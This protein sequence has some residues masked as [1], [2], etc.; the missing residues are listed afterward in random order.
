M[1]ATAPG[2]KPELVGGFP[3]PSAP[4]A[5]GVGVGEELA[6]GVGWTV[7]VEVDLV[8]ELL[9]DDVEAAPVGIGGFA[10]Q[11]VGFGESGFPGMGSVRKDVRIA[12]LDLVVILRSPPLPP[13]PPPP[14][15]Y[16]SP[17]P[18]SPP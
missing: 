13:P 3:T 18:P 2:A 6:E 17:F 11:N 12:F 7:G 4:P 10:F 1:P 15:P 14:P 5:P 8:L 9:V 16:P